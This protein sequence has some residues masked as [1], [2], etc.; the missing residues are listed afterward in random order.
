[1]YLFTQIS[2]LRVSNTALRGA[3]EK[4]NEMTAVGKIHANDFMMHSYL[5]IDAIQTIETVNPQ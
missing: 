3:N 5:A 4:I 1:M 2:V